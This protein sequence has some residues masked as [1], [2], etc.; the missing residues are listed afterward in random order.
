MISMT[1]VSPGAA[2]SKYYEKEGYYKAGTDDAKEAS[3]WFGKA[4]EGA[5]LKGEV[6]GDK[7]TSILEGIAPDGQ[8][9]GRIRNGEREHRPGVDVTMNAPKSVSVVALVMG[10]KR[11]VKAHDE[12]VKEVARYVEENLITTRVSKNGDV[13]EV[14]APNL[15]AGLFRHE[16]SRKLD[17]HLH[18]H[19]VIANM[20]KENLGDKYRALHND[21]LSQHALVLTHLYQNVLFHKIAELGYDVE[22]NRKGYV[23]IKGLGDISKLY[24]KRSQQMADALAERGL[25][26]TGQSKQVA[27]LMTR[28]AKREADRSDLDPLWAKEA[29]AIGWTK[30]RLEGFVADAKAQAKTLVSEAEKGDEKD[31]DAQKKTAE[32]SDK[33]KASGSDLAAAHRDAAQSMRSETKSSN[34]REAVDFAI[35]HISER[36]A[37]YKETDLKAIALQRL[38]TGDLKS[39]DKEVVRLVGEK[40]LFT[41]NT[42]EGRHVSDDK[43]IAAERD[44]IRQFRKAVQAPGVEIEKSIR[45]K[46]SIDRTPHTALSRRLD[47]TVLSEGQKD[48][49]KVVLLGRGRFVAIQGY[50]GTGKTFMM[51]HLNKNAERYGYHVEG[52]AP[53]LSATDELEKVLPYADTIR[54]KI[55]DIQNQRNQG[56]DPGK[57]ILIVD[58]ASMV[59]TE[60]MQVLKRAANEAGLAKVVLSGDVKQLEPPSAGI[61]FDQLQRA[62]MP[63]AI[64]DDIR[65]QTN[66]QSKEAVIHAMRG[67]IGEAFKKITHLKTADDVRTEVAN[68]WL[69]LNQ[70][71]RADTGVVVMTNAER[72]EVNGTIREGLRAEGTLRGPEVEIDVIN[73]LHLT[74]AASGDAGSYRKG[75]TLVAVF[76]LRKHDIQPRDVMT[77]QS[78]D[79]EKNAIEVLNHGTGEVTN[80]TLGQSSKA[81]EALV[82]YETGKRSFAAGDL[83]KFNIHDPDEGLRKGTFGRI[84]SVDENAAEVVMKDGYSK[85]V[86]LDTLAGRG[87]DHAYALTGHAFQGKTVPNIIVG[88]P[89]NGRMSTGKAAYVTISRAQESV[90]LVTDNES[91]LIG[92]LS[93]DS[94]ESLDALEHVTRA[95]IEDLGGTF[96]R[97]VAQASSGKVDHVATMESLMASH[98][99]AF[100]EAPELPAERQDGD[101]GHQSVE[102]PSDAS[103][104]RANGHATDA[105]NRGEPIAIGG[106][107]TDEKTRTGDVNNDAQNGGHP[108]PEND[109][110]KD[111]ETP[112]ENAPE[113]PEEADQKSP[114]KPDEIKTSKP[115]GKAGGEEVEKFDPDAAIKDLEE[116]VQEHLAERARGRDERSR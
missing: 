96:D 91:K 99:K 16:T 37:L 20:V 112:P 95:R 1:K 43:T 66:E 79:T 70:K 10:D 77:V 12:A 93:K 17:P 83:V 89:S 82:A 94:G 68:S 64:M 56:R 42:P 7:F 29:A 5:G 31:I 26:A 62:G 86:P 35:R 38:G 49:I 106:T 78:M 110:K 111:T 65:R 19:F 9:M 11:V 115:D 28:N 84:K 40:R 3:A 113:K 58:E 69:A 90:M 32:K 104:T 52:I 67:E 22:I 14:D 92:K 51:E 57:T 102:R 36:E 48:A 50:A 60:D 24:S 55:L 61:P 72:V 81:A 80:I 53:T 97:S 75:D 23:E 73:P 59:S 98:A 109:A 8:V 18:T 47:R 74:R 103:E 114:T 100:P 85:I 39:I 87:M 15:I 33:S 88:L 46:L 13:Q 76:G 116:R 44:V 34:A 63:T 108:T 27:A 71:T 30:E 107:K 21:R 101:P 54:A 2:S 41:V 105:Q 45:F 4:A 25:K 6:D